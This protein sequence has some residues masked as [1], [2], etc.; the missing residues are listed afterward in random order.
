MHPNSNE[1]EK[2]NKSLTMFTLLASGECD[3]RVGHSL[4][5]IFGNTGSG[6]TRMLQAVEAV[7]PRGLVLRV[8]AETLIN[9]IRHRSPLH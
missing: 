8:G 4:I 1:Y 9:E 7:I 5:C 6:K 3:T 2:V